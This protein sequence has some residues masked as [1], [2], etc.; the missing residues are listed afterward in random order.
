MLFSDIKE[1]NLGLEQYDV[2]VL[3]PPW[4]NKH[5]KRKRGSSLG[6]TMLP[7]SHIQAERTTEQW[8]NMEVGWKQ[9]CGS[10]SDPDTTGSGSRVKKR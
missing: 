8:E 4:E 9:C 5:V 2:I 10:G 6:Y 1:L 3:D 7:N